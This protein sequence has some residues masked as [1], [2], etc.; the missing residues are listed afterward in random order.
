MHRSDGGDRCEQSKE[1]RD[2][3]IE[4]LDQA[5]FKMRYGGVLIGLFAVLHVPP[6]ASPADAVRAAIV[7]EHR[8]EK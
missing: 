4:I 5:E 6:I 1:W 3:E 2:R 7:A 8:E